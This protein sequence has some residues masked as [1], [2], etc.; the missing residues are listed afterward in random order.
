M[1]PGL[2]H[3]YYRIATDH[4]SMSGFR[5]NSGMKNPWF[6]GA[7]LF[8]TFF[9]IGRWPIM[10]GTWAS[11]AALPLAYGMF[12]TNIFVYMGLTFLFLILGIL[13]CDL[14]EQT[15][16]SHDDGDLVIDEV[17]GILITLTWLPLTWQTFV[18][19]FV[20]FRFF[21][22]LKPF[23]IS[24]LD[25]KVKGGLG[26]MMDDVAAGL[27]A[28]VILQI[29]YTQTSWLGSQMVQIS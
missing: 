25:K 3:L 10:P 12:Q 29:I 8:A 14:V 4:D 28:N 15:R 20:L 2:Q 5:D 21:D 24:F 16:Q 18:F 9:G 1:N 22:I 11:L 19:G 23:P 27:I 17:V 13:S 7:F 6:R 26:V